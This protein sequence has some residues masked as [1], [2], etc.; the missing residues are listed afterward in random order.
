M[1]QPEAAS[2]PK[3]GGEQGSGVCYFDMSNLSEQLSVTAVYVWVM[4]IHDSLADVP[5]LTI[6]YKRTGP[7][8]SI[9]RRLGHRRG[10]RRRDVHPRTCVTRLFVGTEGALGSIDMGHGEGARWCKKQHLSGARQPPDRVEFTSLDFL[11]VFK[12]LSRRGLSRSATGG[13]GPP[14]LRLSLRA[15]KLP[16]PSHCT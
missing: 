12:N 2:S 5:H 4:N 14:Q 8:S 10:L 16:S 13:T 11:L 9:D 6:G 1:R 7:R 15:D 3:P